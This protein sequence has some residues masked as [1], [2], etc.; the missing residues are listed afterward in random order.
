MAKQ[1]EHENSL[2]R[3]P[4]GHHWDRVSDRVSP[5]CVMAATGCWMAGNAGS[6]TAWRRV[7]SWSSPMRIPARDIEAC[8]KHG[9]TWENMAE[10]NGKHIRM[11]QNV[12]KI[13]G[14]SASIQHQVF[15]MGRLSNAT[16]R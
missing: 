15:N 5:R 12:P 7:S 1:P 16:F 11:T 4:V 9:K 14:R 6:P 8:S 13:C 2:G 3:F 10:K